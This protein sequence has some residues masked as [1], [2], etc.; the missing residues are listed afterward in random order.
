MSIKF[1]EKEKL[2]KIDTAKTSYVCAVVGDEKF[3]LHAYYGKKIS[4]DDVRY[5]T[6][7]YENPFTPDTN[8]RDRER[9]ST[10]LR[11]SWCTHQ[12]A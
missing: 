7:I 2:F 8:D 11:P 10:L 9:L 3:L 12:K 5:L 6:R 1:L 4:D